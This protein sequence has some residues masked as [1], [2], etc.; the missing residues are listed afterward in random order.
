MVQSISITIDEE[1]LSKL[2]NNIEHSIFNNRS[3]AFS[4]VMSR[5]LHRKRFEKLERV[6]T[7]LGM[8]LG[9][10]VIILLILLGR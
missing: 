3:Q 9:I 7:T 6:V 1:I 8:L 4:Y 10:S 5:Y 2:D